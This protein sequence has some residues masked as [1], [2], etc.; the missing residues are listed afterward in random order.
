ML[1]SASSPTKLIEKVPPPWVAEWLEKREQ[2]KTKAEKKT[3]I[4]DETP[5]ALAARQKDAVCRAAKREKLADT[6]TASLEKWLKDF[7][8]VGLANAQSAPRSF[9]N[10]QAA[11]IVDSQFPGAARL[12]R[13]MASLPGA[14]ADWAEVLLIRL[15]R[16]H[17][18]V[19]AYQKLDSLPEA[20]QHDIRGLLGWPV[21]QDEL[22]T[23]THGISHEWLVL[24]S[25]TEL[26]EK[27]ICERKPIGCKDNMNSGPH[28][29]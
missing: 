11:R 27:R 4:N 3:Q 26:E 24:H 15:A 28:S 14:R 18:L 10:D 21:N 5:E 2:R 29:S 17:I 7:A 16:L 23:S 20:T 1:L 12:I 19:L 6:G 8:H 25:H 9:W 22:L 13:E